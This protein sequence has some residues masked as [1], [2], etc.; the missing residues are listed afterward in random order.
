MV[1]IIKVLILSLI[2]WL[3]AYLA[4]KISDLH[5]GTCQEELNCLQVSSKISF[6]NKIDVRYLL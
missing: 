6:K 3:K 5:E 1:F 2:K 4:L